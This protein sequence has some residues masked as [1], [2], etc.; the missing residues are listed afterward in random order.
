MKKPSTIRFA[1]SAIL[2]LAEIKA[3]IKAFDRGDANLFDAL[4]AVLVAIEAY[5]STSQKS[6]LRKRNAA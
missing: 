2:T 1:Q 4:D 6:P 3:A 5:R